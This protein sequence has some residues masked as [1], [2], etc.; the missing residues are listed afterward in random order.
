MEEQT[1]PSVFDELA[2]D[3]SYFEYATTGQRF[4]NFIIDVL[5][6]YAIRILVFMTIAFLMAWA[7]SSTEDITSLFT[8]TW[9][10]YLVG[11]VL[12]IIIYTVIEGLTKGRTLGKLI[13]R[14][15]A[16]K[17][18]F[19]PIGWNEAFKRTLCRLIPFDAISALGGNPWHDS[20]TKTTVI[21]SNIMHV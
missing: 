1:V 8:N 12:Y 2:N 4:I 16:V 14:T 11:I 18:D 13:T 21:K 6:C 9:F 19:T 20:I 5:V 15:I 17:Q 3:K 7:G 10:T